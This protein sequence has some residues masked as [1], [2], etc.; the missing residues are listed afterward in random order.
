MS[1]M[2][3]GMYGNNVGRL[4]RHAGHG[5]W[6]GRVGTGREVGLNLEVNLIDFNDLCQKK[7]DS[8]T[9]KNYYFTCIKRS[10]FFELL[11]STKRLLKLKPERSSLAAAG[12]YQPQ[13][14]L[15]YCRPRHS[16][17][18]LSAEVDIWSEIEGTKEKI[19]SKLWN[20]DFVCKFLHHTINLFGLI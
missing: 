17:P 18:N 19:I 5:W 13:L 2:V 14:D 16:R 12:L 11:P 3:S 8:F 4:W 15:R 1:G 20:N 10:S 7:I 9:D 6:G